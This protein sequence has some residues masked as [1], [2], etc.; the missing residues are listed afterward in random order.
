MTPKSNAGLWRNPGR[1]QTPRF[2]PGLTSVL[3]K[4]RFF[5]PPLILGAWG[6]VLLRMKL[7]GALLELQNPAY[8]PL[9][10][11][12]VGL[13]LLTAIV[14]PFLFDASNSQPPLKLHKAAAGLLLLLPV[15][16]WL[17]LP[18]KNANAGMLTRR[19][20]S[21]GSDLSLYRLLKVDPDELHDEL[22]QRVQSAGTDSFINLDLL[23]LNRITQCKDLQD[24]YQG[25]H[26][27]LLGQW[28][29]GET[30]GEFKLVQV[31]MFCCAAD[32]RVVGTKVMGD[33]GH[34]AKGDWLE[35]DA[36]LQFDEG[37]NAPRLRLLEARAQSGLPDIDPGS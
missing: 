13:L 1:H 2:I 23:E 4:I 27:T 37:S 11:G 30:G 15:A 25:H 7:S 33:A 8:H 36:D 5:L 35:V 29:P 24:A 20:T 28:L 21:L 16:A 26:V 34:R 14:Y 18:G 32:A 22:L 31:I 12:A 3:S 10:L 17:A 19:E 9:T 6:C